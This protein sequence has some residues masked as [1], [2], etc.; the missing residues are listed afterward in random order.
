MSEPQETTIDEMELHI[1]IEG[2]EKQYGQSGE[3]H[4]TYYM[5]VAVSKFKKQF[6]PVD[7]SQLSTSQDYECSKQNSVCSCIF[8]QFCA[9]VL[10]IT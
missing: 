4:F 10:G 6:K 2:F 5:R 8:Q 1:L 3:C 9:V 7:R